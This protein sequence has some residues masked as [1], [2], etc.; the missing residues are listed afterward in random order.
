[1]RLDLRDS[2]GSIAIQVAQHYRD[3]ILSGRIRAGE[4]LPPIRTVARELA[5]SYGPINEAFSTLE[6]EGLV[7]R[8]PRVGTVVGT[9]TRPLPA[10]LELG[11]IYRPVPSWRTRDDN[12]GLDMFHGIQEALTAGN[13]RTVLFTPS[14]DKSGLAPDAMPQILAQPAHGFVVDTWVPDDI[15]AQLAAHGRPVVLLD[16]LCPVKGVSSVHRDNAQG[17]REAAR[18]I[19]AAGH[20]VVSCMYR[21]T[22]SGHQAA[23]AFLAAMY[24]ANLAI[25]ADRIA[26]YH[27]E[28]KY[29]GIAK[30]VGRFVCSVPVPTAIYCTDDLLA[31]MAY[32]QLCA[33]GLRVPEDISIVGTLDLPLAEQLT[34]PL[35]TFRFH[36]EQIGRAAVAELVERCRDNARPARDIAVPGAW[37]KRESLISLRANDK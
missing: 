21:E 26:M 19:V 13:H 1:M 10:L 27:D 37:V 18:H 17:A 6:A 33:R 16:R 11:V 5:I 20:R 14:A 28:I 4:K 12:Y 23:D 29:D 34:P 36:P 31:K 2:R 25:P 9:A 7:H 8:R 24:K 22:W 3:M 15:I 35:T 32:M 30:Y